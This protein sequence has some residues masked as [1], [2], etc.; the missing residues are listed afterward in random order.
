MSNTPQKWWHPPE[1]EP[2]EALTPDII[3]GLSR[4]VFDPRVLTEPEEDKR[5]AGETEPE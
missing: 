1:C 4:V 5:A 3:L 2:V